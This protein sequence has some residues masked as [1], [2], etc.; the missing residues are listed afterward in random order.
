VA[1]IAATSAHARAFADV[2]AAS[3]IDV[4]EAFRTGK[5]IAIDA[6]EV[7]SRLMEA[8]ALDQELFDALVGR[9]V[10]RAAE[11]GEPVRVFGEI[12]ALLWDAG[13]VGAAVELEALWN[14]LRRQVAFSL[15]CA[16][17]AELVTGDE[18]VQALSDVCRLHSSVAGPPAVTPVE[19][20]GWG[21]ERKARWF[22]RS[23]LA[24]RDARRF[25]VDTL[26]RWGCHELIDD[27]ALVAAEL[28]AN[29]VVHARS[30]LTVT[31]AQRRDAVRISVHDES[32]VPPRAGRAMSVT[33]GGRGLALVAAVASR[34]GSERLDDGKVVWAELARTAPLEDPSRH[35]S[36]DTRT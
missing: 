17:R 1:V 30:D 23:T 4:G 25:V 14:G 3:G 21:S 5:L 16:Y 11:R 36:L 2:V 9:V 15:L 34:W 18:H 26:E 31:V 13:H 6:G 27:A 22:H 10:R 19:P 8:G 29:A 35:G 32:S 24:P 28:S 33:S 12:V 20:V 7:S